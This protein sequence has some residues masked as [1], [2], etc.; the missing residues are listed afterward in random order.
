MPRNKYPEQTVQKIMDTSLRL[1][2]EKGYE[3]TTILD[4]VDGLG[5]LTRGAFYHHFKSK[6]EVLDAIGEK[7]F[8]EVI[9]IKAIFADQSMN[10]LEKIRAVFMSTLTGLSEPGEYRQFQRQNVDLLAN[11]RFLAGQIKASIE[12]ALE[13][14]PAIEEGMIDGSI[15]PGNPKVLADLIMLLLNLWLYPS[16]YPCG[17]SEFF[18]RILAARQA[19]DS[20]GFSVI[21]DEL[22]NKMD[23]LAEFFKI[24]DD[25]L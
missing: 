5:G 3:Q 24:P 7:M 21:D 6:E 2:L 10:G 1:F 9:P 17:R 16:V 11:P 23:V 14:V 20:L 4:I 19:L 25:P 15:A 22:M 8:Y 18:A 13:F 12:T